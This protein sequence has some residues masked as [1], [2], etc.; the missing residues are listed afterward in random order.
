ML[1]FNYGS[2][3][4]W[5]KVVYL[6]SS[7]GAAW[8]EIWFVVPHDFISQKLKKL[9]EVES[10]SAIL[11]NWFC[12]LCITVLF[13][14]PWVNWIL[15]LDQEFW[16]IFRVHTIK[17]QSNFQS[18]CI[19][20][21]NFLSWKICSRKTLFDIRNCQYFRAIQCFRVKRYKPSLNWNKK[22]CLRYKCNIIRLHIA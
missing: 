4:F 21:G 5:D 14:H 2:P 1:T 18:V 9:L 6:N 17:N 7:V 15:Q 19:G 8:S 10:R 3:Y 13:T 12:L 11:S 16:W 22:I 20:K